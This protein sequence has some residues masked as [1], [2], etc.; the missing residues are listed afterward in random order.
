[1]SNLEQVVADIEHVILSRGAHLRLIF[2]DVKDVIEG[3]AYSSATCPFCG[4]KDKF[5][6]SNQ[7]P[8]SSCWRASCQ[9]G[10][11]WHNWLEY[12]QAR[13][14]ASSWLE[15]Y[16]ELAREAGIEW[17]QASPEAQKAYESRLQ[18]ASLLEAAHELFKQALWEPA[19]NRVLSYLRSR[20]YSDEAIKEMELGAYPGQQ[21]LLQA[22]Q[23]QEHEE[24]AIRGADLLSQKWETHPALLLW[25]DKAG[26]AMGLMG[27]KIDE[28]IEPKYLYSQGMARSYALPGL[29]KARRADELILVETPLGAAYLNAQG[30]SRPVVALG[31]TGLSKPQIEAIQQA[32]AKRLILAL[33]MDEAGQKATA[34]IVEK[35]LQGIELERLLIA[36]WDG[37]KALD[38]IAISQSLETAETAVSRAERVGSWLARYTAGKLPE[39][40]TDLEEE[41]ILERAVEQYLWLADSDM[42]HARAYVESLAQALS[43]HPQLLWP[44]LQ[45][46]EERL[47][48]KQS[49]ELAESLIGKAQQA[50][51]QGD[52]AGYLDYLTQAQTAV[53]SRQGARLPEPK[54]LSSLLQKLKDRPEALP[55]GWS[56]LDEKLAIPMGAYSV[57]SA[58]SGHGK[59]TFMLNLLANW[60]DMPAYKDKRFYFYTYEESE[61]DT[62][63]KLLMLWAGHIFK[64]KDAQNFT[65]YEA[66]LK[67]T[68]EQQAIPAIE[69]ALEKYEQLSSSGRLILSS[70]QLTAEELAE[71]IR[72]MGKRG[73]TG[74]VIVDYIQLIPLLRPRATRQL[75]LQAVSQAIREAVRQNGIAFITGS[76]VNE[77]GRVREARD[78][79]QEAALVINLENKTAGEI[80]SPGPVSTLELKIEKQRK[81]IGLGKAELSLEGAIGKIKDREEQ[82]KQTGLCY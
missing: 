66:Y 23:A 42:I 5:S 61:Q 20:G 48:E 19:G 76:Q 43:L 22:L 2:S 75:D 59:T 50:L 14:R 36:S 69:K 13:G 29:E 18:K 71:S 60:L 11:G 41:A 39:Q 32:G 80:A 56:K 47:R 51:Q 7:G 44:R 6:I 58:K 28:E 52:E 63:I 4:E 40:P 81:G 9:W 25:K 21:R 65:A 68:R 3:R 57:I 24:Q 77:E 38:D 17:P 35:L 30:M 1:M 27:R 72:L 62:L 67:A 45:K 53:K 16:Q 74:A 31:G 55:T 73:D 46:A 70:E 26:R 82:V 12:L 8:F 34:G 37:E 79:L 33:D 54:P 10:D 78:I 15:L 64:D 49:R